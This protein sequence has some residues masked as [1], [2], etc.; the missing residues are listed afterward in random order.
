MISLAELD[1]EYKARWGAPFSALESQFSG[2]M[3]AL[4]TMEDVCHVQ[5]GKLFPPKPDSQASV[6]VKVRG[7]WHATCVL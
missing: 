2:L 3:Q 1:A 7:S 6:L 5:S 4:Q